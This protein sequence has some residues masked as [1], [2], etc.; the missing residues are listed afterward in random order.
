MQ[1]IACRSPLKRKG[2]GK[3]LLMSKLTIVLLIAVCL[4]ASAAGFSQTV[5]LS[6]KNASLEKVFLKIRE[7]TRYTFA[8]TKAQLLKA[9]AVTIVVSHAPLDEVLRLCFRDQPL[10]YTIISK[11]VVIFNKKEPPA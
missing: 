9:N 11:T 2:I 10:E 5:S 6:E 7:Q 4:H 1:F 3:I 8:Y